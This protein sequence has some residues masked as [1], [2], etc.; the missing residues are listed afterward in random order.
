MSRAHRA[1]LLSIRE[2]C[3]VTLQELKE[4]ASVVSLHALQTP[5]KR[6]F[7]WLAW[8]M[9]DLHKCDDVWFCICT[10]MHA[11]RH[12]SQ[13]QCFLC[14]SIGNLAND[15]HA[16]AAF[17]GSSTQQGKLKQLLFCYLEAGTLGSLHQLCLPNMEMV[18]L[19]QLK[20]MHMKQDR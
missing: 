12:C 7:V 10:Y 14:N 20:R 9:D 19:S 2:L 1:H 8:H 15:M 5:S 13:L 6:G 3:F 18:S 11:Y 17:H 4:I 16:P